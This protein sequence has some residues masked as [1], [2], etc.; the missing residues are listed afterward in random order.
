[1]G[2]GM[3]VNP[4]AAMFVNAMG[5]VPGAGRKS[6]VL[7]ILGVVLVVLLV[8]AGSVAF[9]FLKGSLFQ[10]KGTANAKDFGIDPAR[11]TP[12][13]ILTA[14]TKLAKGWRSDAQFRALSVNGL[15]VDG[16]VDLTSG[17][18]QVEFFSPS[19][20][21]AFTEKGRQDS[22]KKFAFNSE[23]IVFKDRWDVKKKPWKFV[24]ATPTPSCP[25]SELGKVLKAAGAK[26]DAKGILAV[27]PRY[28]ATYKVNMGP[29]NKWYSLTD[30]K[31]LFS[32]G[33][34]S[35]DDDE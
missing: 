5:Q 17:N 25:S 33:S 2:P 3:P 22:V 4:A 12:E 18:A 34:G 27:H 24:Q 28:G 13:A 31:E 1:M 35:A 11:A 19:R 8:G 23:R 20:V 15:R 14:A 30:C 29:L 6:S 21:A 16:T 9:A 10:P 32:A 26:A 7:P